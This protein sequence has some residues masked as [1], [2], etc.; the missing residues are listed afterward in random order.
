MEEYPSGNSF[1]LL[2]VM[3]VLYPARELVCTLSGSFDAERKENLFARLGCLTETVPGLSVVVKTEENEQEL[4]RLAPYTGDY[5]V[6]EEGAQFYLCA[7]SQCMP[8]V[9][10]L[11]ELLPKLEDGR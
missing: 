9:P 3:D 7:G 11:S 10:E 1:A 2:T 4:G 5:P 6:P 8:P